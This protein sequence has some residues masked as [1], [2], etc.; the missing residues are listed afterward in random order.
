MSLTGLHILVTRP[1]GQAEK[2]LAGIHAAGGTGVHYPVMQIAPLDKTVD[3]TIYQ[4]CKQ[5]IMDIDQFQHIIFIS[6]NA[7]KF[8]MEWIS[9][10]WPQL[11]IG[12]KW[13]G[14]GSS[15]IASLQREN[16][17]VN[18]TSHI[19]SMDSETL[20]QHPDLQQLAQ[21]KVLIVR[22]VGGREYLAEQLSARG[23]T[24]E[25]AE[26]Y[27][28]G[29]ETSP[30]EQLP[31]VIK[32]KRIDIICVNSVESLQHLITMASESLNEL[33]KKAVVVPGERVAAFAKDKGFTQITV[34]NN[35]SDQAVLACLSTLAK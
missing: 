8:G 31:A 9:Q 15:T 3:A 26:C 27:R 22:G 7:V 4:T 35:A 24:V 6:G 5:L 18:E 14:I 33:Q 34:A 19:G 11:P 28:R 17:V 25:Y 16:V 23:A 10:Y 21:Q 30:V 29:I 2:L 1:K 32:E 12:L 20:L 13:Y